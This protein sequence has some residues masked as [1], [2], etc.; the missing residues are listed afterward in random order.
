MNWPADRSVVDPMTIPADATV[1][2]LKIIA[3]DG[4]SIHLRR[5]D[6]DRR[7]TVG[8]T[9]HADPVI[10]CPVCSGTKPRHCPDGANLPVQPDGE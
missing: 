9:A 10:E 6:H 7:L 4:L 1:Q 2:A 3:S 8:K 5:G